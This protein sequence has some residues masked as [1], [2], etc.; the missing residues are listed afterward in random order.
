MALTGGLSVSCA[1]STRRGGV[2]RLWITDVTNITSFTAGSSHEFN[3]VSVPT[4]FYKY[5]YEDFTFSV[6]SEGS[7]ENGSSIINHSVEFTIPKMTK[8]KAAKLQEIVDLCKAVLVVEDYNDH[9]FVIGW[10]SVLEK[11]AGMH[12]VVDQVIGAGL[13]DSNHYVVK[14]TGVS[15][16]LFREYTGD[17]TISA[18]FE[19]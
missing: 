1:D 8:E 15:A 12:M 11:A 3:D 18:D 9:F 17:V 4:S 6:S 7:K 5:Q 13:Q 14:G 19:Q 2:K 16:E 10:C